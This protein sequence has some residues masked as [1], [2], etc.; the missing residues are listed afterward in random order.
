MKIAQLLIVLLCGL[1]TVIFAQNKEKD[2]LYRQLTLPQPDT[3]KALL[4]LEL[5]DFCSKERASL[6]NFATTQL[7]QR[8]G[9]LL[10]SYMVRERRQGGA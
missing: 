8:F 6:S 7:Y 5:A 1:P 2:S 3:T 10:L 9:A 4:L